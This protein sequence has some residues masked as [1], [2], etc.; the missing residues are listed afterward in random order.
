MTTFSVILTQSLPICL[1]HGLKIMYLSLL[2]SNE[3]LTF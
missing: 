2:S 3:F 1:V